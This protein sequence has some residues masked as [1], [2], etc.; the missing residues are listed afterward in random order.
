MQN[1]HKKK[2]GNKMKHYWQH[3]KEDKERG[4]SESWYLTLSFSRLPSSG[5]L[6]Q[7]DNKEWLFRTYGTNYRI[8]IELKRLVKREAMKRCV[9]ALKALN[10]VENGK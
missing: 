2:K 4:L 3:F 10:E 6:Y 7:L 9:A 5:W 8:D 1:I